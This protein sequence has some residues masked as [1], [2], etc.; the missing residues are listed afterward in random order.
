MSPDWASVSASVKDCWEGQT[1]EASS[2][3]EWNLIRNPKGGRWA[4]LPWVP[5]AQGVM[6]AGPVGLHAPVLGEAGPAAPA[7]GARPREGL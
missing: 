7:P 3:L 4:S 1:E 2:F 6:A 5:S